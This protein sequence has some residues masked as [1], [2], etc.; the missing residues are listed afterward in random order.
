MRLEDIPSDTKVRPISLPQFYEGGSTS[1]LAI[2]GYT[3][4][5]HDM[6]YLAGRLNEAGFTV[7][8]PRLP[9]HGTNCRDFLQSGWRDWLRA[10]VDA[11]LNL[12]S[13][14]PKVYLTGLSMGGV[15]A[16]ILAAKF[17]PRR[18]ALAAPALKTSDW[19][20]RITPILKFF[21]KKI[22]RAEKEDFGDEELNFLAREYWDF[23]WPSK[24]ADLYHLQKIARRYLPEIASDTLTIVSRKDRMVPLCVADIIENSI[25]AK[26]KKRLILEWS[27]HVVVNDIEKERVAD[28]IIAWFREEP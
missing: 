6:A 19:R 16:I 17:K 27:P 22:E 4:S 12:S 18:I 7:S 15:L 9:G 14:F 1:V 13:R 23:D 20:I 25:R 21:V 24:A 8:V 26:R 3:G 10:C 2:H 5:P 28:E 11:Y